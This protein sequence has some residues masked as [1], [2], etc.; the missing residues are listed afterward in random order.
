MKRTS[1]LIKDFISVWA[2][3]FFAATAMGAEENPCPATPPTFVLDSNLSLDLPKYN[4]S[5]ED[6][7]A[8]IWIIKNQAGAISKVCYSY[9]NYNTDTKDDSP[10]L[11]TEFDASE[12]YSKN[13][14]T[15]GV[16]VIGIPINFFGLKASGLNLENGGNILISHPRS[17][18]MSGMIGRMISHSFQVVK[19]DHQWGLSLAGFPTNIKEIFLIFEQHRNKKKV[20]IN[21]VELSGSE[22]EFDS[23]LI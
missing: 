16:K 2:L 5:I 17:V 14:H 18:A 10:E 12:L 3:L 13:G 15:R 11:Y 9:S 4:V 20:I 22:G 6:F 19:K 23:I 1:I 7:S 21:R 8:R